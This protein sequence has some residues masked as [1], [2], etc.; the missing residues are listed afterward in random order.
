MSDLLASGIKLVVNTRSVLMKCGHDNYADLKLYDL[1]YEM[2]LTREIIAAIKMEKPF[3]LKYED[4]QGE[5]IKDHEVYIPDE[6]L[7]LLRHMDEILKIVSGDNQEFVT[8]HLNGPSRNADDVSK[9]LRHIWV[10]LR[11]GNL[12]PPIKDDIINDI[13]VRKLAT[14]EGDSHE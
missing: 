5:N 8:K 10:E 12:L 7:V 1:I 14:E 2:V 9:L 4:T 6:A 11:D 3:F 13:T